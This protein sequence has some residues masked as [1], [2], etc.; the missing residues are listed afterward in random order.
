M[1][2]PTPLL[3]YLGSGVATY[4]ALRFLFRRSGIS[5]DSLNFIWWGD[6]ILFFALWV[7]CWPVILMFSLLLWLGEHFHIRSKKKL[8]QEELERLARATPY[9]RLSMDELLAAQRRVLADTEDA[10]TKRPPE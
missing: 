8:R 7:G 10:P 6:P 1:S 3:A 2:I 4:L 5:T 9:S